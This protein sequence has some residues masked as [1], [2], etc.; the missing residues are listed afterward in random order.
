MSDANLVRVLQAQTRHRVGLVAWDVVA[1]GPQ[2]IRERL[3]ALQAE[4]VRI[5][6]VDAVSN[7]DLMQ[8]GAAVQGMALVTAGSGVAI[9]LP[10]N[11]PGLTEGVAASA[12]RLPV[13]SGLQ[14]VVSGSCSQATNDQVAD[15]VAGGRPALAIDP[16]KLQAGEDVVTAAL[17]W[18][19]PLLSSGPVLIYSTAEPG[20]VRA[21]QARLGAAQAGDLVEHALAAVARG[22]VALGV[23]QLIVAGG[24]T[25]GACVQALSITQ[26]QI[27]G[28]IDPGV[29]W[30]HAASPLTNA[31][32]LHLAL[33]SGNFGTRD[34]FTKA[35]GLLPS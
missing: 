17:A 20:A 16:L 6:V 24:E 19:A 12:N 7:S 9:G 18:A 30:C 33:K 13:A 29:P 32:G 15:F 4:G 11:W 14:A 3:A 31:R 10:Q 27:G 2:A 21:V 5:A 1:R 34:F 26:L 35:F 28:Q 25:S 8:I 23:R 22:L